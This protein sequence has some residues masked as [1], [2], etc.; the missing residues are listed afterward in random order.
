MVNILKY[1][2]RNQKANDL[3]TWYAAL[4]AQVLPNLFK[5]WRCVDPDLFY[6]K[7]KFGPLRF[8]AAQG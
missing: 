4:I 6:G 7:V 2:L 8:C 1:L 5:W 3:E